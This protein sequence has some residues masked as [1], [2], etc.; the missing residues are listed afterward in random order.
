MSTKYLLDTIFETFYRELEGNYSAQA[1]PNV[2][3]LK[4]NKPNYYAFINCSASEEELDSFV[5]L[6]SEVSEVTELPETMK[7]V[8]VFSDSVR[9]NL[10]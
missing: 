10:S 1:H 4:C 5:K 7:A 6:F 9:P 3:R 2:D 8:K